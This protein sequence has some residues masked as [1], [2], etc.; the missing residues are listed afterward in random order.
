ML[1]SIFIW[2]LSLVR[3][4]NW[5]NTLR[6]RMSIRVIVCTSA[7]WRCP[8]SGSKNVDQRIVTTR[9]KGCKKK[10]SPVALPCGP[11]P[12]YTMYWPKAFR[13][14]ILSWGRRRMT[15]RTS[16]KSSYASGYST[17]TVVA[18][19][20]EPVCLFSTRTAE[21]LST[22]RACWAPC[23]SRSSHG[24]GTRLVAPLTTRSVPVTR[25]YKRRYS[26]LRT[27]ILS[28]VGSASSY[29]CKNS[30]VL[31]EIMRTVP[32]STFLTRAYCVSVKANAFLRVLSL[33]GV[34][35]TRQGPFTT[36]RPAK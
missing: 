8:S 36:S 12:L 20:F 18:S 4:S 9:S 11:A 7:T 22:K 24:P 31:P 16:A 15:L 3:V 1:P 17:P 23:S 30:T 26:S 14:T 13:T 19:R 10:E 25:S 34:K 35:T 27:T 6:I 33:N 28:W 29:A 5:K 32:S 2:T 21:S